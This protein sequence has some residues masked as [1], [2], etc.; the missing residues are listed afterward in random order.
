[1]APKSTK[2][3]FDIGNQVL[4]WIDSVISNLIGEWFRPHT[5]MKTHY[6]RK[7]VCI[8]DYKKPFN[9]K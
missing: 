1:M 3:I 9:L 7:L 5:M 6:N 2:D 8:G 4:V